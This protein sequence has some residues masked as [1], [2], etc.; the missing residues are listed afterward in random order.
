[1]RLFLGAFGDPGHAF[2]MLALGSELARR[3]HAVTME[4]WSRWRGDVEA[5]GMTFVAAPE[6]PVFPTMERPMTMYEAVVRAVSKTRPAVAQ[7]RPD[8]VVHDILTLAPA[9][10]GELEGVPVATLIPH[11]HPA[12]P[13]ARRRTRSAPAGRGRGSESGCGGSSTRSSSAGC[14]MDSGS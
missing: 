1:M 4:T 8:A 12:P 10:A 3:G 5:A 13:P 7:A 11:V 6:Y 14:A 9:L 2:P